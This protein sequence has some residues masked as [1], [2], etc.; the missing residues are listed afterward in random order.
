MPMANELF[1]WLYRDLED[2][3]SAILEPA[4][5]NYY[6]SGATKE[7][8]LAR[9]R[10]AWAKY[11]FIPRIPVER[12]MVSSRSQFCTVDLA[13]P[14]Y[15][16]PM[17]F[18]SLLNSGAESKFALA[19]NLVNVP[20]CLSSRTTTPINEVA[21]VAADPVEQKRLFGQLSGFHKYM[22]E[23]F[24]EKDKASPN[25]SKLFFQVYFM[26]EQEVTFQLAQEAKSSGFSL[27]FLTV[28]TPVL[29]M[30]LSD[31]KMGFVPPEG[32][33]DK[34]Y[35]RLVAQGRQSSFNS[36]GEVPFQPKSRDNALNQDPA[37]G[38]GA[39]RLLKD[40]VDLPVATKGVISQADLAIAIAHGAEGVV[41]SNHGGRQLDDTIVTA[42]TLWGFWDNFDPFRVSVD[43]GI[44]NGADV[45][46]ALCMGAGSVGIGRNAAWAFAS[47][48]ALGAAAYLIEVR[49]EIEYAMT[50]L[51][52]GSV[53]EL[54]RSY[55]TPRMMP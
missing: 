10:D 42:N 24:W 55:I 9:S 37:I 13:A 36:S 7:R 48:G 30:R 51:G 2:Q 17:A 19:A 41:I 31:L 26:A 14:I 27:L 40:R 46:K 47:G 3:A 1:N 35:D 6:R 23:H 16:A 8:T 12:K 20:Y 33:A 22:L 29:G 45:V 25:S 15:V 4:S 50:L 34:L 38:L 52:A 5:F 28:D 54:D 11:D 32:Y 21:E 18:Q 49:I 39:T 44:A 43:G 53:S